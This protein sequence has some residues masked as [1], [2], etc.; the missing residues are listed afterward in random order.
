[1]KNT[2]GIIMNEITE[3]VVNNPKK[4]IF[5]IAIV[6]LFL[7][8]LTPRIN[9]NA[10][11]K[12]MVPL[13]EPVIKDLEKTVNVF[14]SQDS[15][16][17]VLKSDE[18]FKVGSL[19]KIEQ[20]SKEF[21]HLKGVERV[22]TPLNINL[23]KSKDFLIEIAPIVNHIPQNEKELKEF[24]EKI[25][26]TREGKKLI[27]KDRKSALILIYLK[28][29]IIGTEESHRLITHMS[30]IIHKQEGKDKIYIVG[31]A[32]LTDYIGGKMNHDLYFLFPLVT[33]IVILI[34][35][36]IFR[37][38]IGVFLPL[39]TVFLSVLWTIGFMVLIKYSFTIVSIITPVILVAIGSAYGIHIVN[40]YYEA[41]ESGI[42]G[43]EAVSN[44]MKEMNSP[45]IMTALTTAG[46]FFTLITSFVTPIRQFGITSAFGVLV[47]M[48]LSLILIPAILVLQN[49]SSIFRK[50]KLKI[51]FPFVLSK[52]GDSISKHPKV[53]IVLSSA[54]LV[55]FALGIPKITTEA[56]LTRY[57]GERNPLVKEIR[58]TENQFGGSSRLMVVVDTG[59]KNGVKNPEVLRKIESIENYLNSIPHISNSRSINNLIYEI[60]QALNEN[61]PKYYTIPNTE[62]AVAQ[63]LLLFTMQ[64]GSDI[65]SMVSYDFKKALITAQLENVSG[66]KLK[67]TIKRIDNYL[68]ENY[69]NKG[70]YAKLV[71]MP[72][73]TIRIMTKIFESQI[74]SF[75]ISTIMVVIIVSL[76]FGSLSTGLL[77]SLPLLLTVIVNFGLMGYFNIPLD[78]ATAMIA[79]IAIGIGVD[80]SIH[81]VSRYKRE[82]ERSKD[83]GQ[84]LINTMQTAG[85]GI[86]FNA[87]TLISGFG[88][89]LFSS[90]YGISIFGYLVS[91]TMLVSSLAA[92]TI[93]PAVLRVTRIGLKK[94]NH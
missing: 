17:V 28:P 55:F 38:R 23:I 69:N 72:K 35:Y 89:L 34:L 56:D 27:S 52:A 66:S 19:K 26:E 12:N 80:Y 45:I 57:L 71:G 65:Y 90:F 18:I 36:L 5:L 53:V 40:K 49:P 31:D 4:C 13:D 8:F 91:L 94:I 60:N 59:K 83:K 50:R 42:R 75:L 51:N 14:G 9:F 10:N 54:I 48:V 68:E 74:K 78:V 61:N 82:I 15:L 47:A 44:T 7:G 70:F 30:E 2:P 85:K 16:M 21:S 87:V 88:V 37:S 20:L 1:M 6:S 39:F 79:S 93:I 63:E 25:L 11:M 3:F 84:A 81:F 62:K 43:K 22:I 64:G 77:C 29:N 92:L 67:K 46:G 33:L 58:L 41:I 24:K 76:L 86:V 73:V 32:Y